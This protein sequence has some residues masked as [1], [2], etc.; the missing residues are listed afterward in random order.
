MGY[1][2][3]QSTI[4]LLQLS[5]LANAMRALIARFAD[6]LRVRYGL[7]CLVWHTHVLGQMAGRGTMSCVSSDFARI[8]FVRW[9]EESLAQ[10]L[11]EKGDK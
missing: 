9:V 11:L 6:A 5:R 4:D 1:S 2:H 3:G 10:S 8:F 7:G